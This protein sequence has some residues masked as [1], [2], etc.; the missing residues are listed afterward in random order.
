MCPCPWCSPREQVEPSQ[1][2]ITTAGSLSTP[3]L[4][5]EKVCPPRD[6]TAL[7]CQIRVAMYQVSSLQPGFA[8][9]NTPYLGKY[10]QNMT[11]SMCAG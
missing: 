7:G 4:A 8:E 11:L 3:S 2:A 6:L 9:H 10:M 5:L 1:E